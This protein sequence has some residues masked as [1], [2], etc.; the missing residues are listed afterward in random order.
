MKHIKHQSWTA[1]NGTDYLVSVQDF[2][3][4]AGRHVR[5]LRRVEFESLDGRTIGS[6][7]FPGYLSLHLVTSTELESL[8]EHAVAD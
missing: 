2:T 8:W 6:T 1:P 5:R 4:D 7:A 3:I